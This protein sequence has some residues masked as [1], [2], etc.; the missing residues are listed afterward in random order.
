VIVIND[1]RVNVIRAAID[2]Q[3][4]TLRCPANLLTD[5]LMDRFSHLSSRLSGHTLLDS[6]GGRS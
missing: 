1:L 6:V 4:G 2:G 5:S 3:A